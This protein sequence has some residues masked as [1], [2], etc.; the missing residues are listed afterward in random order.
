MKK[1]LKG[2][3][4]YNFFCNF[5]N[6]KKNYSIFDYF[7]IETLYRIFHKKFNLMD[8]TNHTY[9]TLYEISVLPSHSFV[10]ASEALKGNRELVLAAVQ[11]EGNALGWPLE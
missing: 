7:D 9:T 3:Q 1:Y 10:S 5:V 2:L 11:Q 4:I 6:E 8:C